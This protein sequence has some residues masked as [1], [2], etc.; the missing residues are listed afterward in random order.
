MRQYEITGIVKKKVDG[1][2]TKVLDGVVFLT[3]SDGHFRLK[4]KYPRS[5]DVS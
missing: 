5:D 2:K 1:V 3:I 4:Y